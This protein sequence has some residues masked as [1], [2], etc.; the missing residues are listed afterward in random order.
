MAHA[1]AFPDACR[2]GQHVRRGRRADVAADARRRGRLGW[3][4]VSLWVANVD[5]AAWG[6]LG[7]IDVA[8]G[9]VSG[10]A[11][12]SLR[13]HQRKPHV[14]EIVDAPVSADDGVVLS[15]FLQVLAGVDAVNQEIA[16]EQGLYQQLRAV[17]RL[18]RQNPE[19]PGP[20]RP[21][22]RD[23]LCRKGRHDRWLRPSRCAR[24]LQ[25]HRCPHLHRQS[26][27]LGPRTLD[28]F[29]KMER[30]NPD[31]T[32]TPVSEKQDE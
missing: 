21:A 10:I 9:A 13:T 4:D 6:G 14:R 3:I 17:S 11:R 27:D 26:Q 32:W 8:L 22:R 23:G 16:I 2:V 18:L 5:Y 19:R 31:K 12:G 30:F 20:R 24:R 25:R 7:V 28:E 15:R 29:N 1:A